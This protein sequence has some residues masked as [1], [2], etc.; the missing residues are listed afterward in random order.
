M[1]APPVNEQ[2]SASTNKQKIDNLQRVTAE[3]SNRIQAIEVNVNNLAQRVAQQH[4]SNQPLLGSHVTLPKGKTIAGLNYAALSDLKDI[5]RAD[6]PNGQIWYPPWISGRLSRLYDQAAI[7]FADKPITP[8]NLNTFNNLQYSHFVDGQADLG[9]IEFRPL[10][11]DEVVEYM[12][13]A[14]TNA[15]RETAVHKGQGYKPYDLT[16]FEEPIKARPNN[17]AVP[18]YANFRPGYFAVNSVG[19]P[20]KTAALLEKQKVDAKEAEIKS[21]V[22]EKKLEIELKRKVAEELTKDAKKQ[23]T[24]S[25]NHKIINKNLYGGY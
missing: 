9:T 21:K 18:Q 7:Y 2:R 16:M 23:K 8:Q 22:A 3:T 12:D 19:A 25:K 14:K 5:A 10:S 20:A 24:T 1:D 17:Y 4:T 13:I 11:M 6:I 15:W